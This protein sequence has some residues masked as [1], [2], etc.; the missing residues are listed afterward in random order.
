MMW[1]VGGVFEPKERTELQEWLREKGAP[2]PRIK[3]NETIFEYTINIDAQGNVDWKAIDPPVWK[4]PSR[5]EFSQLLLPTVDSFRAETMIKYIAN[6]PKS[7]ISN[8]SVLTIGG[9]GT[10]K[11][12][13]ILMFA[14]KFN[15]DNMLF[16]RINFSSAT[17]PIH[18]Q[19]S[20]ESVCETKIRKGF[21]P[22]DGKLMTVFVDDF[23]MPEKNEWGDQITLEI[24]RQLMED[25]FFYRLEKNERGN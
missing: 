5:I 24:V 9:P 22:K 13:S 1:G 19:I 7:S 4:V 16:H 21:G 17:L 11:T 3:E 15:P 25:S 12:S 23:S 14:N 2:L 6:Q 20:I 10:A 8:K 18:F